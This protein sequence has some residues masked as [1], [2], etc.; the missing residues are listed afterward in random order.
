MNNN[1]TVVTLLYDRNET[2]VVNV[3][4]I[5]HIASYVYGIQYMEYKCMQSLHCDHKIFGSAD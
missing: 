3:N 2:A 5:N 4:K 1:T